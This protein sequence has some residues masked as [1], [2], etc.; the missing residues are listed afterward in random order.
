MSNKNRTKIEVGKF[1]IAYGGTPHP[2][3]VFEIDTKHNTIKSIKFGTTKA[4][5]MTEIHPL[6]ENCSKQYV[7]NRPF[8]GTRSDYGDRELIGLTIDTRDLNIINSIKKKE[9]T[10]TR[11]AKAR[12]K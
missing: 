12:Y 7:H 11:R 9:S 3:Y 2:S 1:Y 8:E 5:H 10:K 4:K 6:Q